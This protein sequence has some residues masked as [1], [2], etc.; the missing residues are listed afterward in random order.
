MGVADGRWLAIWIALVGVIA[1]VT[2]FARDGGD[3]GFDR[4]DA[5]SCAERAARTLGQEVETPQAAERGSTWE[6][7]ATGGAGVLHLVIRAADGHLSDVELLRTG[8]ADV[9]TRDERLAIL[10]DGC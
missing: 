10:E 7:S 9:L 1:G 6:V 2:A 8:N 3:G 4:D 5:I